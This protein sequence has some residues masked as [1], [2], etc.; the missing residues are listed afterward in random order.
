MLE[1]VNKIYHVGLYIRLS[2]EDDDKVL[3]SESIINQKSLLLQYVKENHLEVY[4]IYIDDGYSGTNFDRPGFNRLL[5]DIELGKI[6]MVITKDMSRLGRDYIG[7]GNFVEKYFPKHN[8][9]YIAV[10]DNIDTFLDSSNNDMAPFKAI[11][12]DMY[13]KD[14]SKKIKSSLKAKMKEGKWVGGRPPF[15]YNQDKN[16][17]NHLVI[18]QK[19]AAIVKRIFNMCLEGL[20]FYQIAKQLTNERIKTPAQYYRFEW[21]SNHSVKYGTWHSKTIR[22]ILTNRMYIGDLVQNKRSKV[23]YKVKKIVKNDIN[24][25]IVV[26]NTHKA[27]IDK[28]IFYEVQKRIPKNV[29]RNEKKENHLFDGLLYCGD[30]GHRISI[31]SRRKKDNRCYTICNYYRTYMKQR[32]C[33][34]H[35]NNYDKLEQIIMNSLAKVCLNYMD[36][37][38]IKN[39]VLS[40]L[41][42][43]DKVKMKKEVE[44]LHNDIQQIKN[45]LDDIYIDKLNK[46]ITE[47]QFDRVKLKLENQLSIKQ[48][49]YN[50]LNENMN[51]IISEQS[52]D[53]IIIEYLNKF[54]SMKEPHRELIVNLVDRIEIFEDK[55]INIHVSFSHFK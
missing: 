31:T 42:K 23:N 36:K 5:K 51:A 9:R 48:K 45:N 26:E 11:M 30:C 8:V 47:E 39:N 12:N 20:S 24:D 28:E 32:I 17:K 13:A 44:T 3:M 10:T 18:N 46:K 37:D 40:H 25:Y 52:K 29:G 38:K 41:D 7:T 50:D 14:I 21:K 53:K 35:S 33:T 54:L 43:N 4:D 55:A 16:D 2:R 27:I 6:N 19:Q 15:G 22:D 49:R 34:T 1:G